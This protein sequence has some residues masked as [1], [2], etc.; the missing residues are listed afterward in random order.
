MSNLNTYQW[1]QAIFRH[2]P[3]KTLQN[4]GPNHH[5][6][7][8]V[9]SMPQIPEF[10]W[11]PMTPNWPFLSGTWSNSPKSCPSCSNA[12]LPLPAR[13]AQRSQMR[14][15]SMPRSGREPPRESQKGTKYDFMKVQ[16]MVLH[17]RN[18]RYPPQKN[19]Q[20]QK[21]TIVILVF[22]SSI[23]R[24]YVKFRRCNISPPCFWAS[25]N[26]WFSPVAKKKYHRTWQNGCGTD[27]RRRCQKRVCL[28]V[29]YLF[30]SIEN[31]ISTVYIGCFQK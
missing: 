14:A 6:F 10:S 29:K 3:K 5:T 15:F 28:V 26:S 22:Q 19:G 11:I 24:G 12:P 13:Q 25:K 20:S 18:L 7:N 9:K 31:E 4:D 27:I 17:P 30:L 8:L 21:E 2:D 23:S 1:H 16:L